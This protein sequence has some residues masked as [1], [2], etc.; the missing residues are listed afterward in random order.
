MA[1]EAQV[2]YSNLVD[3]KLRKTLVKKVG[4]ICNNRYEGSPKAGSVKVPVRDTEVVVN[5][6]DRAKGAKQTS[7]DTTYLTVNIDHDKA[8]NEIIDGFDAESVPGNLVADRLDSAGYSL[9]LQM[10]SDGS[11]ELTTAGT[12]FGNT[13]ALTEKT[14]YANIVDPMTVSETLAALKT[15][16]GIVPSADY[17]GTEKADDFIFAIQTDASTQTKESDW[18]VFAERVKEHSGALNAS[19]EDVAYI[20]AGTVTEKGETQRTFS[21]NG[22]RCVGDPAQ[23][24][25]LSHKVK[26]GSGTDVVFPYIYFS[27]KTGKGEKGE[28]AFI[29][30]A[31]ASGSASNSAGFACDVKGVGVPAEFNYLTVAAAG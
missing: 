30:T 20:R 2:R 22:N 27:A 16:K 24:F 6:Y 26:F 18:I 11:V 9:G 7:G 3:L 14:I 25:L 1:H 15:K 29:V 31:D 10:D 13:T 4:V 28:A 8:V 12:A 17:T 23:D 5:D 21:L 19:T